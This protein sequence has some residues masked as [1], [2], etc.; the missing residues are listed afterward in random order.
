MKKLFLSSVATTAL[1]FATSA[2]AAD[3]QPSQ[4]EPQASQD[5]GA[6]RSGG[7]EEIIVTAQRNETSLQ[8]TSV[9]VQAYT[10][11]ELTRKGVSDIA[12]LQHATIGAARLP[13]SD[14][15]RCHSLVSATRANPG[16]RKWF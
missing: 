16:K 5:A 13:L 3:E 8:R 11:E 9:S 6:T 7:I 15:S 14:R 12:S 1:M 10:A 2:Q 4:V